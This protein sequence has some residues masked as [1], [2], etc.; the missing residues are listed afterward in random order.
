VKKN[1]VVVCAL[2]MMGGG[3]HAKKTCQQTPQG[4]LCISEVDFV[5]F[6]QQAFMNQYQSQ[7]CWAASISMLFAFH[8]HAVSQARIVSD[9]YGTAA[10]IPAGSGITIANQ[11][12]RNWIDDAGAPFTA[13]LTGAYDADARVNTLTNQKIVSELDQDQPM[14]LGART[15]AMVLT[16]VQYYVTPGGPNIIAAGV[17]DPW[18]G[19]GARGLQMD[20][21]YPIE[22][23]G[24]LRFL[25]TA[26][27]TEGSTGPGPGPGPTQPRYGCSL[28]HTDR[29]TATPLVIFWLLT[30]ARLAKRRATS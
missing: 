1:L 24:S 12:N 11:L 22:S 13:L 16:A 20:E 19:V 9:V 3:A 4:Q 30:L 27:I 28:A 18:P 26:R 10:N 25:A 29:A 15:H 17:F 6:A 8:G 21:L 5:Q 14:I 7:W 23:G 2:L